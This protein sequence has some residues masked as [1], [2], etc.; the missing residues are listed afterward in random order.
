MLLSLTMVVA[1]FAF[2]LLFGYCAVTESY[3]RVTQRRL[4]VGCWLGGIG[5]VVCLI[6]VGAFIGPPDMNLLWAS[7]F[8]IYIAGFFCVLAVNLGG[9]IEA[10]L[11]LL[12]AVVWP[13]W[14]ATGRP[15]GVRR[16]M[17]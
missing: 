3:S 15:D 16:V 13:Y 12:R 4:T 2:F 8:A 11:A 5:C 14:W 9:P 1:A 17:D 6:L 10:P 7:P